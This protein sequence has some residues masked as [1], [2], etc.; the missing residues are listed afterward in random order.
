LETEPET[1]ARL[2]IMAHMRLNRNSVDTRETL[3]GMIERKVALNRYEEALVASYE[4]KLATFQ[5][6]VARS[7]RA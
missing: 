7:T 6:A 3:V 4:E 5:Q 1:D 2:G